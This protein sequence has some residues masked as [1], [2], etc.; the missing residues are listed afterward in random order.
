MKKI[1]LVTGASSG[2]GKEIADRLHQEGFLVYGTSRSAMSGG[3]Y[4]MLPLDLD[5]E[6]SIERLAQQLL[7]DH[8]SIDVLINNAGYDLYGS[9]EGTSD[10]ELQQQLKVNFLGAVRMTKAVLP[11]LKHNRQSY[12]INIS[13]LGGLLALPMN[14]AY[15][16]SKFALEGFFESVRYELQA[17]GIK[18][19]SVLPQSVKTQ[20]L[21]TSIK[22]IAA[23]LPAHQPALNK[24]VQIMRQEGENS[25][26][27][28]EHIS[29]KV[30]DILKTPNPRY[31]YP[32][33][34]LAAFMR[35]WKGLYP[36]RMFEKM[37]ADRFLFIKRAT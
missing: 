11:L 5:D 12:I 30:M 9:F 7:R 10:Q 1:A 6:S 18:V 3:P 22:K 33:G 28:P 23:E 32:V 20:S 21:N 34:P 14:A 31:R 27:K 19:V 15:A 13:S 4:P 2:I 26:I 17:Y 35:M 25:K 16:A 24:L 8:Q 36:Q 37:I 29:Q